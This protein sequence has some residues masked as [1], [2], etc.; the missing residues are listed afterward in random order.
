MINN[1]NA[2]SFA[3]L[4]NIISA[5]GDS[6]RKE[7]RVPP[8][9]WFRG[10]RMYDWDLRPTL[11]RKIQ[12]TDLKLEENARIENFIAKNNQFFMQTPASEAEWLEVMQHHDVSTRLLDWSESAAHSLIFTL[13]YFFK[14]DAHFNIDRINAMPCMWVFEP[15]KWNKYVIE[16][17]IKSNAKYAIYDMCLNT[18]ERNIVDQKLWNLSKNLNKLVIK[19]AEHLSWLF[20]LQRIERWAEEFRN[21]GRAGF[22]KEPDS[23]Y[24]YLLLYVIYLLKEE[25]SVGEIPP[26]AVTLP[27]NSERIRAQKGVFTVFPQYQNDTKLQNAAKMGVHLDAMQNMTPINHCL[28]RIKLFNVDR[29]AYEM[30]NQ[31]MNISWIYPEM[32]VVANEIESRRITV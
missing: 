21:S 15:Q 12:T 10:H 1:Y 26:L 22:G 4:I 23:Y 32:P 20:N 19:S 28:H 14:P 27:Y 8:V 18:Q 16:Q 9:L 3:D 2:Y 6:A 29:I 5:I 7:E 30:M 17:V 25:V 11:F 24:L 31:G 13:E